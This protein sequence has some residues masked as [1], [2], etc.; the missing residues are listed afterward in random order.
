MQVTLWGTDAA[1][2]ACDIDGRQ[3]PNTHGQTLF[4][5]LL[6]CRVNAGMHLDFSQQKKICPYPCKTEHSN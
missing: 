6:S 5:G 2:F 1:H 4:M 3:R